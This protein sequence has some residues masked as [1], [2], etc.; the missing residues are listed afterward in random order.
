MEPLTIALPKGRLQD[1]V[2][3]IFGAAGYGLPV[4]EANSRKLILEGHEG[5]LRFILAK[6]ATC[7][8]LW[9]R[10]RR[11]G[12]AGWDVL[13]EGGRDVY[14]PLGLNVGYCRLVLA[15][16]PETRQRNLRLEANPRV[17]T[18]YT[19]HDPGVFSTP[20][21]RRRDH[22]PQR[23][24]EL[25][26]AV[27]LTDLIVDLVQTGHAAPCWKTAWWSWR[28]SWNRR[29]RW[30]SIAPAIAYGTMIFRRSSNDWRQQV[31]PPQRGRCIVST[32]EPL[33]IVYGAD[34]GPAHPAAAPAAGRVRG[35]GG[36]Y[37]CRRG[38]LWRATDP[39]PGGGASWGFARQ[40]RP[41]GTQVQRPH[42]RL[43][44]GRLSGVTGA[45]SLRAGGAPSRACGPPWSW[46]PSASTPFTAPAAQSPG[47]NGTTK[48]APWARSCGPWIGWASTRPTAGRP[49]PPRCSWPPFPPR[50]PACPRS[51][52]LRR[53]V[54]AN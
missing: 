48:A 29:P 24:I 34:D 2:L 10:R 47:C 28:R 42:R 18:K 26:P 13:R 19:A 38:T 11:L 27:G 8:P 30:W 6:P 35:H 36:R 39:R 21:H 16:Q 9:I 20:G 44:P 49:P 22:P 54:E 52:W 51:W 33:R 25:G 14:E 53:P 31:R 4:E 5:R 45:H 37:L 7:L 12:V 3:D 43:G 32:A 50:W 40:W 1:E 46:P 41:G 23:L 17:A 15:G